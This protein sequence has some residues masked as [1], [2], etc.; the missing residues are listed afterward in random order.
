ML[1]GA[2]LGGAGE[3]ASG[4]AS[5]R[6]DE[7]ER[8]GEGSSAGGQVRRGGRKAAAVGSERGG[9]GDRSST[10]ELR[11]LAADFVKPSPGGERGASKTISSSLAALEH[12]VAQLGQATSLENAA[13]G[14]L[15]H[16]LVSVD[17]PSQMKHVRQLAA[18]KRRAARRK[19]P[20]VSRA[21]D[22]RL[23]RTLQRVLAQAGP[24]AKAPRRGFFN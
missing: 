18:A 1:E 20:V 12:V 8:G 16:P 24:P 13:K 10:A 23:I 15:R 22:E 3:G 9:Q 4:H 2:A 6:E 7:K 21:G 11:H 5:E 17:S 14:P 19:S